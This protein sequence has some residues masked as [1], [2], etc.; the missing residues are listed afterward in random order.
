MSTSGTVSFLLLPGMIV[1]GS[2]FFFILL[3]RLHLPLRLLE[4]GVVTTILILNA[5][6]LIGNV[7][8]TRGNQPYPPYAPTFL[9]A[10]GDSMPRETWLTTDMPWA[11]AWY[12][13]HAS[14]WLPDTVGDFNEIYD[15]YN[16]TSLLFLTQVLEGAPATTLISG[17]Y[18]DWL[19]F[20]TGGN[21]PEGFPLMRPAEPKL[22][23]TIGYSVWAR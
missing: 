13:N 16:S 6:P 21:P 17:E 10:A 8:D 22:K 19:P 3:D 4:T 20:V 23:D 14:L 12:G 1:I 9:R 5:G 7:I 2:A 11:E 18:K 15:T